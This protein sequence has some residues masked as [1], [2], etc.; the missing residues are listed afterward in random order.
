MQC[1]KIAVIRLKTADVHAHIVA[2]PYTV[3][4]ALEQNR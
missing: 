2:R 4:A 3:I 1:V